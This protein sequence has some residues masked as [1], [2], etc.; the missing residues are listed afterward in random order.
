MAVEWQLTAVEFD[1]VWRELG[2]GDPVYPID[3]PSPGPTHQDRARL[4]G[5]VL[6]DLA[7]RGVLDGGELP[8]ALVRTLTSL[9]GAEVLIDGRV[10]LRDH[11]R[12]AAT[13]AG[14]EAAMVMQLGDEVRVR[15][16]DGAR[17]SAALAELLPPV[18]PAPGHSMS[19][20]YRALTEALAELGRGG[21]LWEFE[22][23]LR[24]SGVR[25]PDARRLA[26]LVGGEQAS[27][28][29]FGVTLRG[30]GG[31]H[32]AGTVSWFATPEGGGVLVQRQ[33]DSDWVSVVPGDAARLVVR[34]E[35]LA[36]GR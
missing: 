33:G 3:V 25:G 28:A 1:V 2:L 18:P 29:Q 9:A 6:E 21:G 13:R 23:S 34:L 20:S 26:G 36:A 8:P 7:E 22:H 4:V 16:F 15:A 14:D 11:L 27:G 31:V 19:L 32:R 10:Q 12:V 35:E 5:A 17:L 24:T 30:R